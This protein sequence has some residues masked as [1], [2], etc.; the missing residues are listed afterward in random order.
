MSQYLSNETLFVKFEAVFENQNANL[1]IRV[2]LCLFYSTQTQ[3]YNLELG[4]NGKTQYSLTPWFIYM[5]RY[6]ARGGRQGLWLA[7]F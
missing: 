6:V 5:N 7:S 3:L 4:G 1:I 2:G